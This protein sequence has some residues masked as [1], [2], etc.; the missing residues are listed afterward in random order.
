MVTAEAAT[1]WAGLDPV[2]ARVACNRE[3]H[4]L[5]WERGGL[6]APDH[7]DP[8]AEVTLAALGGG[9]PRC[10]E[11]LAAWGLNRM[12][13]ELVTLGRRPGEARV[14]FLPADDVVPAVERPPSVRRAVVNSAVAN[15][16]MQAQLHHHLEEAEAKQAAHFALRDLLSLP[17][18]MIDR[19][20]VGI[21]AELTESWNADSLRHRPRLTAAIS[22]RGEPALRRA[23]SLLEPGATGCR[24]DVT[25]LE[26]GDSATSVIVARRGPTAFVE[27]AL[28]LE[29]LAGVWGRGVA[30][31]DGRLVLALG[32]AS[33][34]GDWLDAV[35][36]GWEPAGVARWRAFPIAGRLERAGDGWRWAV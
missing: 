20:V 17:T 22:V 5:R 12:S 25:F 23:A 31:V 29:W 21:L 35:H 24:V 10:L 4:V 18:L 27:A 32:G 30:E 7:P 14:G 33:Q 16:A 9:R 1:W 26:P 36:A 2:E 6:V 13:V 8:E 28:G 34:D 15:P 11:L 19:L 3:V